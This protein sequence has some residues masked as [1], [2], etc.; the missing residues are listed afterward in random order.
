MIRLIAMVVLAAAAWIARE[1][2]NAPPQA[3]VSGGGSTASETTDGALARAFRDRQSN[4]DVRGEGVVT[5]VLPDDE[6]GSRHQRFILRVSSEQTVLV[7]HNIDLASRVEGLSPGDTV[8][9]RGEYEWNDRGGVVHWT[10][11][12]PAG[13]HVG[14]WLEWRGRRTTPLVRSSSRSR[15]ARTPVARRSCAA[16]RV[17]LEGRG[18]PIWGP[19]GRSP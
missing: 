3:P 18:L 17:S 19:A 14:G 16:C 12:D 5:R 8:A 15:S 7:S 9:F 2:L 6:E 4:V 11:H 10:H 13:R 1:R